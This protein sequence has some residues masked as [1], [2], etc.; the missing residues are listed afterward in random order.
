MPSGAPTTPP[1]RPSSPPPAGATAFEMR[2]RH[3]RDIDRAAHPDADNADVADDVLLQAAVHRLDAGARELRLLCH[4]DAVVERRGRGRP[5]L[6]LTPSAEQELMDADCEVAALRKDLAD[7]E[8]RRAEERVQRGLAEA[9]LAELRAIGR[10][11]KGCVLSPPGAAHLE[12]ALEAL[13]HICQRDPARA[14]AALEELG[15]AGEGGQ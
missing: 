12:A 5:T 6:R 3:P 11:E 1:P 14:R 13:E 9:A 10:E 7:F 8:R 2:M 15:D 4:V